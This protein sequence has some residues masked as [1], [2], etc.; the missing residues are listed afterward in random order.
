MQHNLLIVDDDQQLTSFLKR[1]FTKHGYRATTVGTAAQT[2]D[3]LDHDTFDLLIL[4]LILPDED[5]LEVARQLRKTT[6][7]PII[8]LTARDEVYDR[9][10]G[11]ELGADDYVTKPY[12]PRELLARVRTVLRRYA[13]A[14]KSGT[15]PH[16]SKRLLRFDDF[17]I[18]TVL[19]S[20]QRLSDQT[21]L[22][23]TSTEFSLLRALAEHAGTVLSRE[24]ILAEVYG[25]SVT[26]TDRAIDAHIA[27]LRKKMSTGTARTDI[28]R[29]IHG[30]GYKLATEVEQHGPAAEQQA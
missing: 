4:D 10:I 2:F 5:G 17:E 25:H 19:S 13:N 8:M 28:I 26:I 30:V 12:E 18:D 20:V 27:R 24:D 21:L 11:L 3:A 22:T 7:I 23:L 1:F 9:V 15:P 14:D 6:D 29:T 16:T